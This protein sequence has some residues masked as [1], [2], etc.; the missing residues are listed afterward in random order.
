MVRGLREA[1]YREIRGHALLATA[2]LQQLAVELKAPLMVQACSKNTLCDSLQL[3]LKGGL[4]LRHGLTCGRLVAKDCECASK[5][6]SEHQCGAVVW[7]AC[8]A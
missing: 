2:D 4:G 8:N 1:A 6:S 7:Q 3:G 5:R